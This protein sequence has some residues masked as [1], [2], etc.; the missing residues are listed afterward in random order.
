MKDTLIIDAK[1]IKHRLDI[2]DWQIEIFIFCKFCEFF[3]IYFI[4]FFPTSLKVFFSSSV[5][6]TIEIVL[7]LFLSLLEIHSSKLFIFFLFF[8]YSFISTFF[9]SLMYLPKYKKNFFIKIAIIVALIIALSLTYF[10]TKKINKFYNLKYKGFF[11]GDFGIVNEDKYFF[12]KILLFSIRIFLIFILILLI[13]RFLP[14]LK[15]LSLKKVIKLISDNANNFKSILSWLLSSGIVSYLVPTIFKILNPGYRSIIIM[16]DNGVVIRNL[17][18]LDSSKFYFWFDND[19]NSPTQVRF[20]GW[21]F[22]SNIKKINHHQW[23]ISKMHYYTPNNVLEYDPFEN[24]TN[25]GKSTILSFKLDKKLKK[26]IVNSTDSICLIYM[27]STGNFYAKKLFFYL[28]KD[29]KSKNI[30][31]NIIYAIKNFISL[32]LASKKQKLINGIKK[33]KLIIKNKLH[34]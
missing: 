25:F 22:G 17:L 27:N 3:D 31:M 6:I 34:K 29:K 8:S 24:V 20:V 4:L 33:I 13:F 14:L 32:P 26:H 23:K 5:Y 21:C 11:E 19:Q 16:N 12:F 7:L 9:Y 18:K 2:R 1:N 28:I 10:C 15:K 30:I